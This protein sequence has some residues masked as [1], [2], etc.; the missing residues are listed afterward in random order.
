MDSEWIQP[1]QNS[2]EAIAHGMT[3]AD[4]S[5]F[6]VRL[7]LDQELV[8]HHNA[9]IES[10][11][12]KEGLETFVEQNH[13]DDLRGA[14]FSLLSE[15]IEDP[16]IK[17]TWIDGSATACI[18]I[19]RPHPK[20]KIA[21][22]FFHRKGM[23]EHVKK[24]MINIE[25]LL[26]PLEIPERN[27][28]IYS[29]DSETMKAHSLSGIQL[30]AAPINPSI[31]TW[32]PSPIRRAM[33][34]PSYARRDVL[35]MA[36]HWREIGAP[37]LP[38]ALKHLNSWSKH[39]HLGRSYSYQG[40]SLELLNK[41][42]KGFPIHVWPTPIKIEKKIIAGGFTALSDVMDSSI[43]RT[44]QGQTR[45]MKIG[46]QPLSP[47]LEENMNR[48]TDEKNAKRLFEQASQGPTWDDMDL[49]ERQEIIDRLGAKFFWKKIQADE[50][51]P[52]WEI[53]RFIGHR[54]AGKTF[55]EG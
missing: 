5:E 14:G 53:P 43:L 16:R 3:N 54:G 6:D 42:R 49:K 50:G 11:E 26:S 31:R 29:F 1:P 51:S 40:K 41:K 27:T 25:N 38:L 13:S 48:P 34:L 19:K 28:V 35:Q 21:G 39:L 2:I 32:G 9:R 55:K 45:W 12:G 44:P 33:A 22:G 30:P 24:I 4:G 37:V 46:T 18:E 8:L 15:L 20:A 36:H 7:T 17:S 10:K 52:P 23:L 47:E